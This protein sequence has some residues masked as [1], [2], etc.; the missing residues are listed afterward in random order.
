MLLHKKIERMAQLTVIR[1]WTMTNAY[2]E[3]FQ[4]GLFRRRPGLLVV[5]TAQSLTPA[6]DAMHL[7][8]VVRRRPIQ[9]WIS[10]P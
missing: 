3:S 10:M 2:L 4:V 9:A 1:R 7:R 6:R 8:A 5:Q